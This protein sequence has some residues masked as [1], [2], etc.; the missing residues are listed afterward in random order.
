VGRL[1][2]RGVVRRGSEG[3]VGELLDGHPDD[4]EQQQEGDLEDRE[5]DRR[6]EVP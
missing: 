6:E 5:V 1:Q 2:G 3:E 4:R